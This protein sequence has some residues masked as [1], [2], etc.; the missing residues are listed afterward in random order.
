MLLESGENS[1]YIRGRGKAVI[2][3]D[4][5]TKKSL[6]HTMP[7]FKEYWKD[8]DDPSYTLLAITIREIEYL[9][10]GVLELETFPLSS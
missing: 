6:A 10:P 3:Q 2:V 8:A 9:K 4:S 1:G 7:F 5:E